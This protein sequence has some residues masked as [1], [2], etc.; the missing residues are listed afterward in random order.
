MDEDSVEKLKNHYRTHGIS[1]SIKAGF[2]FIDFYKWPFLSPFIEFTYNQLVIDSKELKTNYASNVWQLD[3]DLQGLY[4]GLIYELAPFQHDQTVEF[5]SWPRFSFKKPFVAEV[6]DITVAGPDPVAITDDNRCVSDV[7]NSIS[8]KPNRR[9]GDAIKNSISDSLTNVG[10]SLFRGSEITTHRSESVAAIVHSYWDN[11]YHWILE[12]LLKL[13]GISKYT[14]ATNQDVTLIVPSDPPSYIVESL[15]LF[16][17]NSEDY[18][19]WEGKPIHV[20]RLVVPSFPDLTPMTIE[21]MRTHAIEGIHLDEKSND[22]HPDWVYISRQNTGTRRIENYQEITSVLRE[23]GVQP[24][25][26]ENLSLEEEIRLFSNVEG[27][28]GPHGAGLTAAVW[29]SN[30]KIIEIFNDVIK[31]P[32]Y[33]LA[34]VL[35]H[36]YIPMSGTSIES[37]SSTKRRNQNMTIEPDDLR[38]TLNRAIKK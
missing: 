34:Y 17:Y 11:Y 8:Y 26:C 21:W 13:R 2:N 30:I 9:L 36:Q 32:Y 12:D 19:E 3:E 1:S 24:V 10:L 20:D 6:P 28:I 5:N 4:P 16:G 38:K 29:G 15:A 25:L 23:Y 18:I 37:Q 27:I 22:S 31:P 7:I 14:E 33:V 35:D